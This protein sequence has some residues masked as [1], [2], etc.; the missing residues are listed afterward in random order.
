MSLLATL[1]R[2]T[3]RYKTTDQGLDIHIDVWAPPETTDVTASGRLPAFVFFHGGGLTIGA[4]DFWI[5]EWVFSM[6]T[7]PQQRFKYKGA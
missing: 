5:P 3:L 2:T 7:Q 1:Q 6:S 4:R